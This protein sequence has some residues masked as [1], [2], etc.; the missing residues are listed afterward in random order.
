M[1]IKVT[2]D[3]LLPIMPIATRYQGDL[4]RLIKKSSVVEP[5][6]VIQARKIRSRK[7]PATIARISKGE[8]PDDSMRER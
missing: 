5:R 3:K 6:E 2:P 8:I 7:Y 1:E 4:F